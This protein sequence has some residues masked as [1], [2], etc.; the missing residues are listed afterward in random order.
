MIL[1]GG[2]KVIAILVI[3]LVGTARG[4]HKGPDPRIFQIQSQPQ[5]FNQIP[6]NPKVLGIQKYSYENRRRKETNPLETKNLGLGLGSPC[7]PLGTTILSPTNHI[8]IV[9][10]GNKLSSKNL[11]KNTYFNPQ[12][13]GIRHFI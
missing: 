9:K 7:R 12:A 3:A 6:Q 10:R 5:N 4:R 8:G 2:Q 13:V 11:F 1:F